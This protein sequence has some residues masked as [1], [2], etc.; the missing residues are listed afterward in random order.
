[1]SNIKKLK[2]IEQ[3]PVKSDSFNIESLIGQA[4]SNSSSVETLQQLLSMRKELKA[5]WAKGE[6]D[7]AMRDF[8]G[9][10][11]TIE[12]TKSVPTRSGAVAYKYAPIDSIINQVKPILQKH[13]FSY[14]SNMEFIENGTIKVKVTIKITHSV[15]H[16]EITEMTV[17]LGNKTEIMSQTQV[18]A[19][20]QTFAKRYAFCNALGILSGDEDNDAA[21]TMEIPQIDKSAIERIE[22]V[23]SVEELVKVGAEIRKAIKP[24]L[25]ESLMI[26]YARK[27]AELEGKA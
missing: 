16:S 10:C 23:K 14:S 25:R 8:Q 7:R 2:Q 17:P 6:Y 5:E 1:M 3:K 18:V 24:E 21:P 15:G 20:A 22:T 12:K 4:I 26:H 9:E 27:K 13:G 11:P 19:A